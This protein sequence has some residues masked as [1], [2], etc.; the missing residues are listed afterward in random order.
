MLIRL[1]YILITWFCVVLLSVPDGVSLGPLS[2]S[3]ELHGDVTPDYRMYCRV[4]YPSPG[5][6]LKYLVGYPIIL[7]VQ[8]IAYTPVLLIIFFIV[9]KISHEEYAVHFYD[10]VDW[11]LTPERYA[12]TPDFHGSFEKHGRDHLS[13]YSGEGL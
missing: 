4:A 12:P 6:F 2:A 13:I 7:A 3:H 10:A 8:L 1:G 5:F 11:F 9:R